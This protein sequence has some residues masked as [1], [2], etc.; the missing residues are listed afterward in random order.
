MR[1][2]RSGSFRAGVLQE[3]NR[4]AVGIS[5]HRNR[6]ARTSLG[7][8]H[9]RFD[10][11]CLELRHQPADIGDRDREVAIAESADDAASR[12][13]YLRGPVELQQFNDGGS[14]FETVHPASWHRQLALPL[15]TQLI[16]VE[17][18]GRLLVGNDDSQIDGVFA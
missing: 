4:V 1:A 5:Y 3:L 12:R 17:A 9:C 18:K 8:G 6:D 13:F 11:L 16:T 14:A 7:D 10:A 2:S 15:Q